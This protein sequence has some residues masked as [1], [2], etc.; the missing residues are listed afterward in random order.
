MSI[1]PTAIVEDGALLGAGVEI[2]PFCLVG[3]AA[4]LGDGVRLFSHVSIA[5]HTEVGPRCVIYPNAAL[6]G[7]GQIRGNAFKEGRLIIGADG[8][9]REGVT[10]SVGSERGGGLTTIGD[11]CYLMANSHAGHDCHVGNDVTFVN[12]AVLGGH[13]AIGDGAI[14]GGNSAVQQFGRVGKGAFIG[15]MTGVNTDVIP[16][17]QAIGDHAVLGGLNLV[18][19]KRRN[20]PRPTIHA[21]RA[22][23]RL[24]FRGTEGSVFDRAARARGE[25][26]STPEVQEIVDFILA[27]A[28]RPICMSRKRAGQTDAD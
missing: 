1:H 28:K 21:M 18:G 12:G 15:G 10:L 19:L 8:V 5:G 16:Y 23:F 6:G 13:V 4:V 17:G 9:I 22:A 14:L 27:D 25:W 7:E 20:L 11:R 3:R 2:G 24:I 26:P